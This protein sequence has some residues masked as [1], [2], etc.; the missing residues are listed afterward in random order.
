M[1]TATEIVSNT[2]LINNIR[3]PAASPPE[4]LS[5]KSMKFMIQTTRQRESFQVVV[6]VTN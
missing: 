6:S 1:A 4:S 3:S 2:D 5:Q